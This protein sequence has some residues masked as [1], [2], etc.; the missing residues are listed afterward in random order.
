M[1]IMHLVESYVRNIVLKVKGSNI[2]NRIKV[3]YCIRRNY[4]LS[5]FISVIDEAFSSNWCWNWLVAQKPYSC[6]RVILL[7]AMCRR[8]TKRENS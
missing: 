5:G 6:R 2:F 3:I 1:Y 8:S 7:L 4:P